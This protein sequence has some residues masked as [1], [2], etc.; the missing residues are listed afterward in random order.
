L[1]QGIHAFYPQGSLDMI[2]AKVASSGALP[3]IA[4]EWRMPLELASDLVKLSL[5]D[6]VLYIDDSGSMAFEEGGERIDD[7]K[8]YAIV[9]GCRLIFQHSV[10]CR[11]RDLALR[12]RWYPGPFHEQPT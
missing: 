9:I 6:V 10:A 2:A 5:F 3:K 1:Q 12:S 11:I 4:S 7:L 8:L